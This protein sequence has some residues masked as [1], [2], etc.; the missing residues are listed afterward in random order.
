[1]RKTINLVSLFSKLVICRDS[2]PDITGWLSDS[3]GWQGIAADPLTNSQVR[4][5]VTRVN[6]DPQFSWTKASI[7]QKAEENPRGYADVEGRS[8]SDFGQGGSGGRIG[9]AGGEEGM[10]VAGGVAEG[11]LGRGRVV[12]YYYIQSYQEQEVCSKVVK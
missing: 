2:L 12:K 6:P 11:S 9:V 10:G 3:C 4:S 1:L 5:S 7:T 8:P